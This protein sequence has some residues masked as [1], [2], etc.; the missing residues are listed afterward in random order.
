MLTNKSTDV[1]PVFHDLPV[2]P[3]NLTVRSY[4]CTVSIKCGYDTNDAYKFGGASTENPSS[5]PMTSLQSRSS[6]TE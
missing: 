2:I 1:F 3:P 5:L 4:T 6:D